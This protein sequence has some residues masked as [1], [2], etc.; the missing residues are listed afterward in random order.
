MLLNKTSVEVVREIWW[1]V[2]EVRSCREECA[3]NQGKSR[4]DVVITEGSVVTSVGGVGEHCGH[5][6]PTPCPTTSRWGRSWWWGAVYTQPIM[7]V[8]HTHSHNQGLVSWPG[9]NLILIQ[10]LSFS[11]A[12]TLWEWCSWSSCCCCVG[13]WPVWVGWWICHDT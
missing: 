4:W 1:S 3:R 11:P 9:T 5:P 10:H 2:R 6:S 13:F 8:H 7:A 12:S